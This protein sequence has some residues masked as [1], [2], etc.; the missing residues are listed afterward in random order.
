[1]AHGIG[2]FRIFRDKPR[3][4]MKKIFRSELQSRNIHTE[5]KYW[6]SHPICWFSGEEIVS[7]PN[8][9]LAGDAAGIEPA[10]GGGIHIAFSYGEVAACTI[11][12]AFQK[13]DFSF[14]DYK[15]RLRSHLVGKYIRMST[16]LALEMYGGRM[17]PLNAAR[18]FFDTNLLFLLLS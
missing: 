16:R 8:I 15:Q 7:I 13:K 5:P 2:D 4:D 12:D 14:H 17:N 9:L 1:M 18:E 6:S 11:I 3:A 10:F